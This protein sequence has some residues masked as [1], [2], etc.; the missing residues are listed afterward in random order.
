ML[1]TTDA[2]P[3][4]RSARRTVVA[5]GARVGRHE[6]LELIGTGG[7]GEVY[8]ARNL[9]LDRQVAIKVV[10]SDLAGRDASSLLPEAQAMAKLSHPNVVVV[11][12]VGTVDEQVYLAMEYVAGETLRRW[13]AREPRPWRDVLAALLPAARG[14]AAAHRAGIVHRDFK[15]DNVLVGADGRVRVVDFGLAG[16]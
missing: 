16:G 6:I 12:E 8:R 13:L 10:R 3:A 1:D 7:M 4:P 9:D 14:L 5:V 2:T 11:Y 15:P